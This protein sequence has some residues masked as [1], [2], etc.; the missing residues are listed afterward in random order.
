MPVNVHN[1]GNQATPM[2]VVLLLYSSASMQHKYEAF[3]LSG[4]RIAPSDR[5]YADNLC[6]DIHRNTQPFL[7][8]DHYAHCPCLYADY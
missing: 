1:E 8:C 5:W 2:D 6:F 3:V 4:Q 7:L